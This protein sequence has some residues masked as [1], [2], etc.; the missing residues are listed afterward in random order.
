MCEEQ[1]GA[2]FL[3]SSHDALPT[4]AGFLNN[5]IKWKGQLGKLSW[6]SVEIMKV[7][8][9]GHNPMHPGQAVDFLE[10][11]G[12]YSWLNII[13][14]RSEIM[15]RGNPLWCPPSWQFPSVLNLPPATQASLPLLILLY[16]L[17]WKRAAVPSCLI[18]Q[19]MLRK[20][21]ALTTE[22]W[23]ADPAVDRNPIWILEEAFRNGGHDLQ[24]SKCCQT[25]R[26]DM[27]TFIL[28]MDLFYRRP[29][30]SSEMNL[31]SCFHR[32]G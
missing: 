9:E 21:Q 24:T 32:T 5:Q 8:E 12:S 19:L 22:C 31:E 26:V 15:K 2:S 23:P 17:V 7:N 16:L 1:Q 11:G 18:P 28:W 13:G 4:K 29:H 20:T 25:G 30:C 6:L 10:L 27:A 3:F 14:L